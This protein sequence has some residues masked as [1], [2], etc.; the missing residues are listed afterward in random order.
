MA[1]LQI[2]AP[3]CQD[4]R[5]TLEGCD[6]DLFSC[7]LSTVFDPVFLL[8]H[9]FPFPPA[10]PHQMQRCTWRPL[11]NCPWTPSE[12]W[13]CLT[14]M[15]MPVSFQKKQW[16]LWERGIMAASHCVNVPPIP[17]L[18]PSKGL[19]VSLCLAWWN[20]QA[21]GTVLMVTQKWCRRKEK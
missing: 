13:N 5:V 17:T 14:F 18:K 16:K 3:R 8:F 11:P 21:T 4:K 10:L 6:S 1:T 2:S 12:W 15:K 19:R 7:I 20:V 9:I